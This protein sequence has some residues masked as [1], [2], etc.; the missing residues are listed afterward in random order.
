MYSTDRVY[1]DDIV[2]IKEAS[3]KSL[4]IIVEAIKS[5]DG[6]IRQTALKKLALFDFD[7]EIKSLLIKGVND[8]DELIRSDCVEL[9]GESDLSGS[10]DL[11]IGAL[12][13]S[14]SFVINSAIMCL[15]E[16]ET[17]QNRVFNILEKKLSNERLHN[18]AVVRIH[19]ALYV[20]EPSYGVDNVLDCLIDS[21]DY[22][23]RCAILNML[24]DYCRDEDV[25]HILTRVETLIPPSDFRSV[26]GD[27]EDLKQELG[28]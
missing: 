1:I 16:L 21:K 14:S 20:L 17:D 13:D 25:K 22:R 9:L 2:R 4:D 5:N 18:S 15:I 8:T 19:Y 27:L 11:I 10:L 24:Y 28:K 23:D 3:A 12:Q 6:E 7:Q 26:M